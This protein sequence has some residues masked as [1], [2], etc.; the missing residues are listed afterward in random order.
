MR[1]ESGSEKLELQRDNNSEVEN[2]KGQE[3][4]KEVE[5][6]L[7]NGVKSENGGSIGSQDIEI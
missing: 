6:K 1:N 2:A 5:K 7:S 3:Q 4:Q